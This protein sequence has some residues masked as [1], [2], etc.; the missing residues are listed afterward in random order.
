MKYGTLQ[1]E[2]KQIQGVNVKLLCRIKGE[3]KRHRTRNGIFRREVWIEFVNRVWKEI[4]KMVWP[5]KMKKYEKDIERGIKMKIKGKRL[6]GWSRRRLFS[7][8]LIDKKT[9]RKVCGKIERTGKD[10]RSREKE[11]RLSTFQ[12]L[13]QNSASDTYGNKLYT[14]VVV[15][16]RVHGELV[17]NACIKLC[18][19]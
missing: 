7:Q 1:R 8:V 6:M 11:T 16:T 13:L 14:W 5:G 10:A 4:I 18:S 3:M 17:Y 15:C 12:V 9:K 2:A 19:N